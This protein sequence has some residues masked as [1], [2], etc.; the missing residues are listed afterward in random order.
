M[1][2]KYI[3]ILNPNVFYTEALSVVLNSGNEGLL[4]AVRFSVIQGF[5]LTSYYSLNCT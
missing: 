3:W 5:L 1:L 2:P 4:A